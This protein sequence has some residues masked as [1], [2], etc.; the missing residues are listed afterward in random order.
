MAHT[1]YADWPLSNA[2]LVP[3]PRCDGPKLDPFDFQGPHTIEFLEHAG[4]GL[5]AH[6]FKVQIRGQI[7]APKLVGVNDRWHAV[8]GERKKS[9]RQDEFANSAVPISSSASSLTRTG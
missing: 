5:H 9:K 7:Y 8:P 1:M 2:D 6:V 3:L 4:D